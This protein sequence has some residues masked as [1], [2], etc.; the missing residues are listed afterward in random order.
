MS[1][2]VASMRKRKS[3][4][5]ILTLPLEARYDE[6]KRERR[7]RRRRDK[8]RNRRERDEYSDDS[9]DEYDDR[10][11]RMLEAGPGAASEPVA[12]FI[13]EGGDHGR[14]R[15]RDR[16]RRRDRDGGRDGAY[17]SGGL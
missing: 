6:E 16:E 5:K 12:D 9:E 4:H 3:D 7:E 17:M 13:R 14:D 10:P 11:P 15:D 8:E 1:W 2:A